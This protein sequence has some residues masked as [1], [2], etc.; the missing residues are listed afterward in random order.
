MEFHQTLEEFRGKFGGLEREA[1]VGRFREPFLLIELSVDG[2]KTDAF[3][4]LNARVDADRPTEPITNPGV[5]GLS[6]VVPLVK[7]D[8]NTFQNMVTMGRATNNDVIVPHPSVS[9]FHA[10]FRIDPD[11]GSATFS[12]A[13]SSYG[14]SY[15]R[16]PVE[17]GDALPVESGGNIILA[18]SVRARFFL[19]PDLY[20]MLNS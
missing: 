9:K 16:R 1:F 10:F 20:D 12:D 2:K 13:G 7:S 19:A 5:S 17:K 14:S 15:N 18:N 11:T 6:L 4:T 8:R 3:Q